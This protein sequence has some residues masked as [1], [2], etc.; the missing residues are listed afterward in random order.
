M[1]KA[2]LDWS[3]YKFFF[4]I[5]V[6]IF[7]FIIISILIILYSLKKKISGQDALQKFLKF[8]TDILCSIGYLPFLEMYFSV[9][10]CGKDS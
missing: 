5:F 9:F 3:E 10:N 1:I 8:S 6:G 4:W 2:K 7:L